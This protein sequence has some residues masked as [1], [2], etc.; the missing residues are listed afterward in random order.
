MNLPLLRF[1]LIFSS[2]LLLLLMGCQPE[3]STVSIL[4]PQEEAVAGKKYPT[5]ADLWAGSAEF[6]VDIEDT[7]LPMGESTTLI[8]ETGHYWSYV[9][10]SDRSAGTRDQCGDPVEF[11]GCTVI[12]TSEDGTSFQHQNPPICQ[13]KCKRCPCTDED[14]HISQQQYPDLAYHA[15]SKTMYLVYEFGGSTKMRTSMDGIEWSDPQNVG[16]SGHWRLTL[17]DCPLYERI[18]PHPFVPVDYECLSG[19]PPGIFIEGDNIYIFMAMGQNPGHMGCYKGRV[20]RNAETYQRCANNPLFTGAKEYGPI[21]LE[22]NAARPYWDF[23]T[24]SSAE[25]YPLGEGKDRRFYMFYE[26]IRGPSASYVAGDSQFGIGFARTTTPELDGEWEKYD[27]N[28]ILVDLPGNIGLAH[29][30]LVVDNGETLMY[31]S[32][33]GVIRSRL[34]LVWK[35]KG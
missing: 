7:G 35:E 27:K 2:T 19:A 24:I 13:F 9:H 15:P 22:G 17:K 16:E 3:K 26:G 23:R 14:D 5:L 6:V 25:I 31:T 32:L 8:M 21:E 1:L 4:I 33:D 10:A 28:P 34:R 18:N 12:Y 30:D 29:T 20:G 11:P